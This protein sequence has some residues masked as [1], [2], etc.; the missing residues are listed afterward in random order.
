LLKVRRKDLQNI[1][2]DDDM[3]VK[4]LELPPHAFELFIDPVSKKNKLR[5]RPSYLEEQSKLVR[6]NNSNY[7]IPLK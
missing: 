4:L 1:E 7:L 6:S 3:L 5:I 2:I